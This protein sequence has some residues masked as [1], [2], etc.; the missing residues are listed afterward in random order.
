[1]LWL[2]T[3]IFTLLAPGALTILFPAL[4][5]PHA[6]ERLA[7]NA[8]WWLALLPLLL[9]VGVY[10][11]CVKD[12][13]TKGRG[14]PAPYDPPKQLVVHGLYRYSRNPMYL[15]VL[16]IL[17]GEAALFYSTTLLFYAAIV[18]AGFHLRVLF[19]EE[20]TLQRLFGESF[21]QYRALVPR[22]FP[23]FK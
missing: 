22:W 2:K 20:P 23:R 13:I 12:F 19:Y 18:F 9:G 6:R 5:L 10:L 16:L 4:L 15:G 14:T 17:L 11:W 3:L 7:A 8:W 1:M 21:Q